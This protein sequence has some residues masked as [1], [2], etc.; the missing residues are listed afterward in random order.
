MR[1]AY[2]EMAREFARVLEKNGFA[3]QDAADSADILCN[4]INFTK[5]E[6]YRVKWKNFAC[7]FFALRVN[8]VDV[9]SYF[10]GALNRK[11]E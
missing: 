1:V 5:M 10:C 4:V 11:S 3:A 2:E 9:A 8:Y 6:K 7:K